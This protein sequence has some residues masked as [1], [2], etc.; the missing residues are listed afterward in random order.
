[1]ARS[2]DPP[3]QGSAMRLRSLTTATRLAL[4]LLALLACFVLVL[5]TTM[6]RVRIDEIQDRTES[7]RA[8]DAMHSQ[9]L[10]YARESDLAY[11]TPAHARDASRVRA[12][13]DLLSD[14]AD[15]RRSGHSAWQKQRIQ[16][17]E[18]KIKSYLVARTSAE[19]DGLPLQEVLTSATPAL[20]A[21]L[22]STDALAASEHE[23]LAREHGKLRGWATVGAIVGVIVACTV[24]LGFLVVLGVLRKF[25]YAPLSAIV[26][27]VDR[28]AAGEHQV[29]IAPSGPAEFRR[30][31]ET[32][33]EIADRLTREEHDRLTFL[34]GVAHDLRNPLAA[35]QMAVRYLEPDHPLPP[36]EKIR[37]TLD[38][39]GRQVTLMNRMVGDFLDATRIEGGHLELRLERCDLRGFVQDV[40]ELY[41]TMSFSHQIRLSLP[42]EPLFAR[43]DG[44]RI[45]Q[46][47]NNFLSNAIKYSPAGGDVEVSATQQNGEAVVSVSDHG[48]GIAPTELERIFEPFRRTGASREIAAGVG[49]GLSVARR[50]VTAHGGRIEVES[51]LGVGSTFRVRLP[52]AGRVAET[53]AV[54][55]PLH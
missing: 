32:L 50:I 23:A 55:P 33:N 26:E 51:Q 24:L 28:Y 15:A 6:F 3:M 45:E 9:L 39:V 1:M 49:L 44:I 38:L 20:D 54:A 7:M 5:F 11:L 16:H 25:V 8:A 14:V 12:E 40:V 2:D 43:C 46:V 42:H 29:R 21:A 37:R 18:E 53:V 13:A 10:A 27:S 4:A 36:E 31:A 52:L 22:S 48:I 41:K 19:R 35:L 47:L 17:A 34:G 30:T